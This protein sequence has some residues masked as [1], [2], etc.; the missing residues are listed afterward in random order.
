MI[1]QPSSTL[2]TALPENVVF[3]EDHKQ[4]IEQWTDLY[5]KVASK[6][7]GKERAIYPLELEILNDQRF[8]TVG[9][10][11]TYR[12]VFR[13]VFRFDAIAANGLPFPIPHGITGQTM[14]TKIQGTCITNV[15]DYRPIPYVSVAAANQ[16]IQIGVV[17]NNIVIINGAAAAP[18]TSGMVVLEYLKN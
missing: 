1:F 7:N 2:E 10:T 11:R 8:F 16:C 15:V 18:I 6:V 5:K 9:D 4:F 14:F 12:S 17:G 13:K 3:S